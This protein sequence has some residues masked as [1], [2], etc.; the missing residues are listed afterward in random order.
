M[1]PRCDPDLDDERRDRR[2]RSDCARNAPIESSSPRAL[3]DLGRH[4][5]LLIDEAAP[6]DPKPITSG[7][8]LDLFR[9][10]EQ[11][12]RPREADAR[13]SSPTAAPTRGVASDRE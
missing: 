10:R 2:R 11:R 9:F 1:D 5:Q 12:E 7:D 13:S 8:E 3:E 6:S 4:V